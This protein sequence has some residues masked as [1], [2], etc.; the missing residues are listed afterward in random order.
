LFAY[1]EGN[2]G[3]QK[4][5]HPDHEPERFNWFIAP[6][7]DDKND[8]RSIAQGCEESMEVAKREVALALR[9]IVDQMRDDLHDPSDV[10]VFDQVHRTLADQG[11][12]DETG[13]MEYRRVRREW[14]DAGCPADVEVFISD[15]ANAGP[16]S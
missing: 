3:Y 10:A 7:D 13:G 4:P 12:C 15:R 6:D 9:Q 1:V 16:E 11:R 14:F 5:G 8:R 2:G